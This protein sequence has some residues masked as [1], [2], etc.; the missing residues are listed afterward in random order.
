M[1]SS[2]TFK[3]EWKAFHRLASQVNS[4]TY[5][6]NTGNSSWLNENKGELNISSNTK[7]YEYN[8]R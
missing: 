6:K 7:L 4:L 8:Q 1:K 5:E 3:N 2:T